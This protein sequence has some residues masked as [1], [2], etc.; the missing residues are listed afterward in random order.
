MS[1]LSFNSSKTTSIECK[2]LS[3]R[4]SLQYTIEDS[5]DLVIDHHKVRCTENTITDREVE[6]WLERK[7]QVCLDYYLSSTNHTNKI[8]TSCS[9]LPVH[10]SR[11]KIDIPLSRKKIIKNHTPLEALIGRKTYRK[12][13]D[14]TLSLK[15]FSQLLLELKEELFP[16]I[17]K[18]YLVA[19]NVNDVPPGIYKYSPHEHG[20]SLIKQGIFR[21]KVVKLLCGMSA[22]FTASFVIVLSI[23]IENALKC[24]SYNRALREIYIDSGRIAQKVL[25]RGMQYHIGGLPSPAMHDSAMC[26]FLDINPSECIPLYSLTMGII[27]GKNL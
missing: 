10:S 7:W 8:S 25:I 12:F 16:N 22:S 20:L 13:Q 2:N 18:Y 6:H 21:E 17:W 4:P 11:V 24:Y 3:K 23:D 27:S 9:S 1:S 19:F 15:V 5:A 14:L 26:A